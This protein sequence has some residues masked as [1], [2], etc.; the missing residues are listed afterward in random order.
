MGEV[1]LYK[2]NMVVT[3][4]DTQEVKYLD[5]IQCMGKYLQIDHGGEGSPVFNH[6]GASEVWEHLI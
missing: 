1:F 4:A 3:Y 5:F 2:G 6:G